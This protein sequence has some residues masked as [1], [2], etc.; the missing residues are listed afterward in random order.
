MAAIACGNAA[1]VG[2][3]QARGEQ[4]IPEAGCITPAVKKQGRERPR[5]IGLIF[6]RNAIVRADRLSHAYPWGQLTPASLPN[7]SRSKI[8]YRASPRSGS[9]LGSTFSQTAN[10]EC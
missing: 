1:Q 4:I 6:N 7:T 5:T 2:K 8:S 10:G 9:N 3:V